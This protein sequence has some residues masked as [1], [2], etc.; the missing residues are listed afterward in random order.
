MEH[1]A[2]DLGGRESQVCIR[3]AAGQI[4]DEGKHATSRLERLLKDRPTSRVILETSSEAFRVADQ[5]LAHGHEVR[6]VPA[7]LVRTLGVGSR[8]V[9]N[10]QRDARILSEVSCRIDLPSVHVPTELSR[11]LKALCGSRDILVSSRTKMI[12]NVRGWLR[13]QLWRVKTGGAATFPARVRAHGEAQATELPSHIER[14]LC[15]LEVLNEQ[16]AAATREVRVAAKEHE[17]CR[18]LMTVPGVGPVTAIRF[19]ATLDTH[20]RFSN[21]HAVQSYL[22][23]TPGENSSSERQRRTGITK[24]GSRHVRHALV[25]AAWCAIRTR[26]ADP[27]V[28]WADRVA[29]RRGRHVA[30]VA[31]ARKMAGVLYALWRDGTNYNP[32]RG[33]EL[34]P[35][36]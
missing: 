29:A 1:L 7:L 8:G 4:L 35:L 5:A 33:A 19:V 2:I 34:T 36:A 18:R 13:T 14:T 16:I 21:A 9:K 11:Q 27:M 28:R 10:D 17:V 30:A 32:L 23:L 24:A 22:G 6:V 12:N 20:E 26:P 3:D 15:V 25:Q 31:L